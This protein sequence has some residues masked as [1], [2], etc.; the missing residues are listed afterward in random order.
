MASLAVPVMATGI[1]IGTV[2]PA[3]GNVIVEVG[4]VPSWIVRLTCAGGFCTFPALSTA[5]HL[6]V[7]GPSALGVQLK[8]QAFVPAAVL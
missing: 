2:A 8:L 4:R 3:V 7:A 1:P 5:R 6:I